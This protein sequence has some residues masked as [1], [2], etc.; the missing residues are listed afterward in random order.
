MKVS[1][2]INQKYATAFASLSKST[3]LLIL[4]CDARLNQGYYILLNMLSV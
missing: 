3:N 2:S 1:T 4:K